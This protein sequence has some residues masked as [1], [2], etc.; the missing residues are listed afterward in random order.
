MIFS[1][2]TC[3][4]P[5]QLKIGTRK[6]ELFTQFSINLKEPGLPGLHNKPSCLLILIQLSEKI[7]VLWLSALTFSQPGYK[8][9]VLSD[10]NVISQ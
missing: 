9:P 6:G 3:I 1:H 10:C 5:H 7:A 4:S 2:K 8:L